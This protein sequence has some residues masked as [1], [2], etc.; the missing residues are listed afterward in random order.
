MS[1]AFHTIQRIYSMFVI[2]R[3]HA[4]LTRH[5]Q[6]VVNKLFKL[7][8]TPPAESNAYDRLV[9]THI[10]LTYGFFSLYV[11]GKIM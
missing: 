11:R 10:S 7:T 3:V 2:I 1:P 6:K 5:T 9:L 4:H 8:F